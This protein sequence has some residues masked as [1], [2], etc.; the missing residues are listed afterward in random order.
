MKKVLLLFVIVAVLIMAMLPVVALAA[1]GEAL[2]PGVDIWEYIQ[3]EVYIL[4]PALYLAGFFAK[5]I[6]K[7]P[8][9]TIPFIV[10]ALGLVGSLWIIGFTIYGFIQGFF[11]AGVTVFINQA[12]KQ[13]LKARDGT[14]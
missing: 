6:P 11:V 13:L 12:G 9:W 3:P 7:I 4:I 5:K 14:G 1:D 10:L 8:D 2:A